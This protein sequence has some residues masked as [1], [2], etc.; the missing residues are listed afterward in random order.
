MSLA[1]AKASKR[2]VAANREHY[3]KIMRENYYRKKEEY[4]D[5]NHKRTLEIT[6][7]AQRWRK[8][9]GPTYWILKNWSNLR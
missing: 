4:L 3:M 7:G 6:A 9:V 1:Q 8:I 2:Y 5:R